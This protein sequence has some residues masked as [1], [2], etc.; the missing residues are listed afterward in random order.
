[1]ANVTQAELIA[2]F[3]EDCRPKF[4]PELFE[5]SN[6][7]TIEEL[8]NVIL[9]CQRDNKFFR[10]QVVEFK[11]VEDYFEIQRILK[12]HED[13]FGWKKNK[14]RNR[15]NSFEYIN[16]K[17]SDFILLIVTYFI[18]I[19]GVSRYLNVYIAV[20]KVVNKFYLRLN[21]SIYSS[22]YQI[23]E[24]ST[25][26]NTTSTTSKKHR[27]TFRT[28][29]ASLNLYRNYVNLKTTKKEQ[30]R[31]AYYQA[32]VFKKSLP[33]MK[34]ILAKY[35]LFNTLLFFN[36]DPNIILITREDPEL[37]DYYTFMKKEGV[38]I[39]TPKYLFDNDR[40]IQSLVYTIYGA[41]LRATPYEDIFT[42]EF[43]VRSLGASFNNDSYDKGASVLDSIERIY[44]ISTQELLKL[45]LPPEVNQDIYHILRW[46]MCEFS[47]L[48]VKSNLNLATK[49]IRYS[50]YIAATYAAKLSEGIYR[51]ADLGNRADIESIRKAINIDPMFLIEEIQYSKLINYRDM[52]TD[53]DSFA[54]LKYTYKGIAGIGE[55]SSNA[56]PDIFKAVN[57]SH[58][59]RVDLNSSSNSD[60]GL[61]GMLCPLAK[62]K[63]HG[64][65]DNYPEPVF[66]NK[67][68]NKLLDDYK[69]TKNL[70]EMYTIKR[71]LGLK[72]DKW[73]PE[74]IDGM[75][76]MYRRI[77]PVAN[78]VD[79]GIIEEGIPLDGGG[80]IRYGG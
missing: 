10:V 27:I 28:I 38:Y 3:D 51:I 44:D 77:L 75:L 22:M 78:R 58:V 32:N 5:R 19:K 64:F 52:V 17:D 24:T 36:V 56:V 69:K 7:R 62:F 35:G 54:P 41:I 66:W 73:E 63:E 57:M 45:S 1:M 34:Y 14:K 26:N 6:E 18:S 80:V 55:K 30:L 76:K 12:N 68:F 9:S 2:R 47:N 11:V 50:E 74:E 43:W 13:N 40:I 59:G 21:G 33:A 70:K 53:S 48:R 65:F 20:P 39:S 42:N 4:N 23:L 25:Y 37:D 71:S 67:E 46:L 79:T 8:K 60:P 15:D 16:L 31:C 29:L 72:T 49:R 61:S